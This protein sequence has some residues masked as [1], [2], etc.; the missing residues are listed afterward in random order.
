[1]TK[2]EELQK[3]MVTIEQCKEQLNALENQFNMLQNA[4]IEQTKAK[5]TIDN[6]G[7]LKNDMEIMMPVGGGIFVNA[8][9]KKTSKV[10]MDVG[11]GVVIEKELKDAIEKINN[12]IEDFQKTEERISGIVQQLQMEAENATMKAQEL[13]DEQ[14]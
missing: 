1:M 4:I 2:E 7:K 13:I 14:K 12:R 3:Y 8:T 5:I 6:L 9:A 11:G 10:L